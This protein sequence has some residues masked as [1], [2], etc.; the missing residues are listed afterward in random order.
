MSEYE[1]KANIKNV[2]DMITAEC[3]KSGRDRY[4]RKKLTTFCIGVC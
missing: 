2:E 3:E 4:R 1:I